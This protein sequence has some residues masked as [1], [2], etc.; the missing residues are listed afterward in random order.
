MRSLLSTFLLFVALVATLNPSALA[1]DDSA[2]PNILLI[3]ADDLSFG[4]LGISGAITQTP[5]I[6][7]LAKQGLMFTRF[8]ASPVC[9]VTRSMLLTGNNPIEVGLAAFDYALYPPAKGKP[10]Y[11]AYLTRT[12]TT[13]AEL[14]QDAGYN[15]YMVGK[16]HLG[17]T[18]IGGEGPQQWGFDHSFGIYTGGSNHWNQGVFHVD[19]HD[20]KVLEQIKQGIIPEEPFFEDGQ[21][22]KRPIGIFSD[23]LYTAK[24]LEYLAEGSSSG[25]PFFAYIAYT[26][27]H[28]PI[29]APDFLIEKYFQYFL[30]HGY[31]GLKRSRFEAQKKLGIIPADAPFPDAGKN[32]LLRSWS[33]L[34]DDEKY[35]A[36]R[37]MATYSAMIE[38]QDYHIGTLLNYLRESGQLDNTLI[39]YMSDNGGEGL[40]VRGDLSDPKANRWIETNFSQDP[41]DIGN[42]DYFAFIGTDYAYAVSGGLSWWK[43]FI[44]EG[45]VRVPMILVPPSDQAFAH[46]GKK[47]LEFASV[48][49]IPMTILDYAG[50]P[51]PGQQY[52]DR[53]I[54]PPSGISMR[55]F[56]EGKK[57]SPRTENDWTAFELFGNAYVVAG[58][59]KAIRV[60]KA[61]YGDGQWHLYNIRNDP[62]ETQPLEDSDPERLK[63]MI[64]I[65][66]DYAADKGIV[67]V[68]ENWSPWHG[69]LDE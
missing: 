42:G 14:L 49:D 40:D 18:D 38:S 36:A 1:G 26:T 7:R 17:G 67:P 19:A 62:G 63:K 11:E 31:E 60:R 34:S 15:T 29:Q 25:K 4:D 5:N 24:M 59:Y 53:K 6:D 50:V 23:D 45:G 52:Q 66:D 65:Y 13:V 30:K 51:H 58:D 69:F 68:A 55:E 57:P 20:P 2:R 33:D 10:G 47:T 37:S 3:V 35:V 8:H 16:W 61:M 56:L 64:A 48:K 46:A 41:R 9:S 39:I 32:P 27:P 43:W 12:T 44:G 22:V 54:T 28:A 21:A